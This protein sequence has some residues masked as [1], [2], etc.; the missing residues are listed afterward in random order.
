MRSVEN[1]QPHSQGLSSYRLGGKMRDPGNEVCHTVTK[2]TA[3][4]SM[5]LWSCEAISILRTVY[6]KNEWTS[7]LSPFFW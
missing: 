2:H 5:Q 3:S 6:G 4:S 1:G 7:C